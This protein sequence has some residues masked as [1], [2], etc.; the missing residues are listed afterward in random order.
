MSWWLWLVLGLGLTALELLSPGG[1]YLIFFGLSAFLI[2]TLQLLGL[3]SQV[4]VQWF[5]FTALSFGLLLLFRNPLLKA[6]RPTGT[7]VDQLV[8]EVAIVIEDI[9]AGGVGKAEL[10]GTGWNARNAHH[11]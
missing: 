3:Q 2:G 4:W 9:T 5:L 8:G 1:F 10:R 7:P 6:F 11:G